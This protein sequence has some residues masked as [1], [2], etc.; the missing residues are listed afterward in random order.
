[1]K[2]YNGSKRKKN[3]FEGWFFKHS[4][5]DL[6]I[7]FI[8]SIA[9]VNKQKECYIQVITNTFSHTFHFPY[10]EFKA[11]KHSL[12][13]RIKN[14]I[15]CEK[16]VI[17]NLKDDELTIIGELNYSDFTKLNKNIMGMFKNFP[18]M[19]CKHDIFSIKHFVNGNI[20]INGNEFNITNGKGYI[21][22]DFGYSFPTKYLWI[23]CNDFMN[24]NISFFFSMATIPYLG[25]S[26]KGLICSL[27]YNNK[28]YRFA[29]Y[30]FSKIKSVRKNKI[31]LK[32]GKYILEIIFSNRNSHNLQ[33]PIKGR[34]DRQIIECING[35]C[36]IIL[37]K[38]NKDIVTAVGKNT[39][40]EIQY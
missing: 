40:I 15:F 27:I 14:N 7:A 2:Y 3:Y 28:E 37:K 22:K 11:C 1:M 35:K 23:Q 18:F 4:S 6:N 38:A 12:Y 17:L 30:N 10:P 36:I 32:K 16:K 8:P 33:A 26:F 24:K 25:I 31:I 19:E 13:I 5:E 29:T 9:I 34:M 21:E 39:G 20:K